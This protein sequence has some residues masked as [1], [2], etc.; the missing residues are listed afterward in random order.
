VD[1]YIRAYL[2]AGASIESARAYGMV[3]EMLGLGC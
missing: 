3:I 2:V 1:Y